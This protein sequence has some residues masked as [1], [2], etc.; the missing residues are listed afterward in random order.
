MLW[1]R[2]PVQRS[3]QLG[4]RCS[5]DDHL[6]PK[7]S[8]APLMGHILGAL[9]H[10]SGG[11]LYLAPLAFDL[12][13]HFLGAQCDLLGAMHRWVRGGC[14]RALFPEM[15]AE[16][17]LAPFG[18][19]AQGRYVDVLRDVAAES[20]CHG[21]GWHVS[22]QETRLELRDV[23]DGTTGCLTVSSGRRPRPHPV[24]PLRRRRERSPPLA[25]K[26]A[27]KCREN[28]HA[29]LQIP[30][31]RSL[32]GPPNS[33]AVAWA[34]PWPPRCCPSPRASQCPARPFRPAATRSQYRTRC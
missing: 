25:S 4:E 2:C 15:R 27:L 12:S 13:P 32:V 16:D 22:E 10:Q 31:L 26:I 23:T 9:S 34:D 7:P 14:C 30:S 17:R 19:G 6:A 24:A 21:T 28:R 8:S 3:P 33:S 29:Q 18:R 5:L 11:Q 20:Q 1:W